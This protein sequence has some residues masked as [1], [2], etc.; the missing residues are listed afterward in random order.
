VSIRFLNFR[1]VSLK[2]LQDTISIVPM[3]GMLLVI[4]VKAISEREQ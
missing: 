1:F 2:S 3:S 4:L